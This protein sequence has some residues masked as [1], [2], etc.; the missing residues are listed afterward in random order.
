[1]TL[2]ST[3]DEMGFLE[4]LKPGFPANAPERRRRI[5]EC[6]RNRRQAQNQAL[7]NGIEWIQKKA[8]RPPKY[9]TPEEASQARREL[10]RAGKARQVQRMTEAIQ[11]A[12]EMVEKKTKNNKKSSVRGFSN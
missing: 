2:Y 1:M 8:S 9:N 11:K 4:R 10:Y 7:N 6:Q 3:L 5:S 12:I